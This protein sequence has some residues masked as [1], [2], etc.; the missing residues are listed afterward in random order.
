MDK[1]LGGNR[2]LKRIHE[3]L[4]NFNTYL[5]NYNDEIENTQQSELIDYKT[6]A[7]YFEEEM[8]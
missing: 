5:L 4:E 8:F 3:E 6:F 7:S 1:F 2:L